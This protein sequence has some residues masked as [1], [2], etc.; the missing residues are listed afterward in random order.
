MKVQVRNGM[1]ET[2]SS[3]TH[4]L[5]VFKESEHNVP[6]ELIIDLNDDYCYGWQ[7][8]T[9][10]DI[11]DK[12]AYILCVIAQ[13]FHEDEIN[14]QKEMVQQ[15][16]ALLSAAGVKYIEITWPSKKWWGATVDHG[17]EAF[18]IVVD[19]LNNPEIL[20]NFLFNPQ[21]YIETGNDNSDYIVTTSP[22]ADYSYYKGN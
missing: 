6:S 10:H 9:Y 18:D 15:L 11:N 19:M 12:L 5:N 21:S 4:A 14:E 16:K 8:D 17:S 22:A 13:S 2:N 7:E 3:S 20:Y 1:F